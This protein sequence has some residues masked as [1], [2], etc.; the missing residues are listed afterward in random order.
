MGPGPGQRKGLARRVLGTGPKEACLPAQAATAPWQRGTKPGLLLP[1]PR[2]R[3]CHGSREGRGASR[4][5][6]GAARPGLR[7][8]ESWQ[9]NLASGLHFATHDG[10]AGGGVSLPQGL[11]TSGLQSELVSQLQGPQC[12]QGD[13]G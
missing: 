10:G 2:P 6:G 4:T 13:K 12:P 1:R 7:R 11:R 9:P 5:L 8:P 3:C